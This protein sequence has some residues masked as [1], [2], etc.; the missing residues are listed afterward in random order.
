MLARCRSSAAEAFSSTTQVTPL[1]RSH[2]SK[3][4]FDLVD[5]PNP[6]DAELSRFVLWARKRNSKVPQ[7]RHRCAE[8]SKN[9]LQMP[10]S[11]SKI[12][13]SSL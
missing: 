5:L 2:G 11:L 4:R 1:D 10:N 6:T 8:Q 9:R 7:V 3:M 12:A 13:A